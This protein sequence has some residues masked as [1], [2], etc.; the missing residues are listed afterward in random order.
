MHIDVPPTPADRLLRPFQ[1]FLRAESSGGLI[2]I[3]CAVL[4][5][6]WANSPW[7][8]WYFELW[9]TPVVLGIGPFRITE[10][11]AHW[12]NDGLMVIFFLLVGLEIKRELLRGELAEP[13]KAALPLAAALGGMVVP[14]SIYAS[15][16]WGSPA[17]RGWGVPMAT[18][19]AFA[20]GVLAL[21]GSRAPAGLK[22]F[23]A[24]VAIVDDLGAVLVIAVFYTGMLNWGALGVAGAILVVLIVLNLAGFRRPL[25]YAVLGVL[26]WLA[27]YQSGVHATVAGVLLAITIPDRRRIDARYFL[28]ESRALL[29]H[30]E[31]D[32]GTGP[33][34]LSADQRDVV[35]ALETAC[36]DVQ[37]PLHRIEHGLVP[38][39]AFAIMP[40]FA[41]A[42]AGA[43]FGEAGGVGALFANR[44]G[45]GILLGLLV[46][47][48]VGVVLFSWLAVR[49]GMAALPSGVSWRSIFGV[50][51]LCGIGFTM[52]L[53]IAGL[54]F[55]D[56]TRLDVAKLAIL[57]ASMVS[58]VAGYLWL[59]GPGR[60]Q[61]GDEERTPELAG[62]R[63]DPRA[64]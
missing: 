28:A 23:L 10:S 20:L 3:A 57:A 8:K 6:A 19:I 15:L 53:F 25:V 60:A 50:S 17:L 44:I 42:N 59:L 35:E 29:D 4:A 64:E 16:N 58:G 38:W 14:A 12:I 39:V 24:A 32:C 5:L 2:L 11:L 31:R 49:L 26:L 46:G 9:H 55:Q 18:D 40:V 47:K 62:M 1:K 61:A 43:T 45:L 22:V 21:L 27:V 48:P 36:E 63:H 7:A 33:S 37:T 54:A 30:F 41:L 13:R 56:P 51:L 34:D 52:A